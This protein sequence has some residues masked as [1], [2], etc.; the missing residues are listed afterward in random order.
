M[1]IRAGEIAEQL[2]QSLDVR[3]LQARQAGIPVD[4]RFQIALALIPK[5]TLVNQSRQVG[6][7]LFDRLEQGIAQM[8]NRIVIG[9]ESSLLQSPL[10]DVL[11]LDSSEPEA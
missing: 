4:R 10:H 11:S 6:A 1:H 8:G 2:E 9:Q 3:I 7:K 5:G